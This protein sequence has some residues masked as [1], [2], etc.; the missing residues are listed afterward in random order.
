MPIGGML[1][2]DP[3]KWAAGTRSLPRGS[4]RRKPEAETEAFSIVVAANLSFARS[5]ELRKKS[6][7]KKR[8]E[9]EIN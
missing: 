3:V 8:R 6:F 5:P 9:R 1:R 4:K 7:Q 2:P